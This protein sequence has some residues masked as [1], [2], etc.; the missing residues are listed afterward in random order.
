MVSPFSHQGQP[1]HS[2]L[3]PHGAAAAAVEEHLEKVNTEIDNEEDDDKMPMLGV[4]DSDNLDGDDI[5]TEAA[6]LMEWL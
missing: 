4:N 6:K 2:E 5:L 3:T 1:L